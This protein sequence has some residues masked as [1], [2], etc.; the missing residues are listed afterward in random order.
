MEKDT[1]K[2]SKLISSIIDFPDFS[3][4]PKVRKSIPEIPPHIIQDF[5]YEIDIDKD[6]AISQEELSTYI[7]KQKLID[8]PPQMA[9]ELFDAIVK[10]RT[11]A[12]KEQFL[13]PISFEEL[14]STCIF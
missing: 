3:K 1:L 12:H 10:T 4:R 6:Q 2:E 9:K 14:I 13:K 8:I 5:L 7:A 11:V